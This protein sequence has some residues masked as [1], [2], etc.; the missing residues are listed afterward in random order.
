M[1]LKSTSGN[2]SMLNT[3]TQLKKYTAKRLED[4]L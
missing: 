2:Q 4:S 1:P 3:S